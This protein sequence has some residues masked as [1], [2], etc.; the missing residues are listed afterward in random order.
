MFIPDILK[1][2]MIIMAV[3]LVVV[4]ASIRDEYR[5]NPLSLLAATALIYAA[6]CAPA[7]LNYFQHFTQGVDFAPRL[8]FF[9]SFIAYW[10]GLKCCDSKL[11]RFRVSFGEGLNKSLFAFGLYQ[12]LASCFAWSQIVFIFLMPV[13]FLA[14]LLIPLGAVWP[15][16]NFW[17]YRHHGRGLYELE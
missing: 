4:M 10:L 7:G 8:N 6:I 17:R 3:G 13:G 16:R 9:W 11:P 15:R 5:A 1:A 2:Q 12:C 14:T